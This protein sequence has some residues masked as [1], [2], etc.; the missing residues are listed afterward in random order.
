MKKN[1]GTMDRA[2]RIVIALVLAGMALTGFIPESFELVALVFASVLGLTALVG[3]C[4]LYSVLGI[5]TCPVDSTQ[6]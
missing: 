4:G 5:K 1:M 3:R 6:Q 2:V